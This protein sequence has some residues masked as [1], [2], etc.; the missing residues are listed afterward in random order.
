MSKA[1]ERERARNPPH[2]WVEQI[3]FK[4]VNIPRLI[5]D[6]I[7]CFFLLFSFELKEFITNSEKHPTQG[8]NRSVNITLTV[9]PSFPPFTAG[10]SCMNRLTSVPELS[11]LPPLSAKPHWVRQRMQQWSKEVRNHR[12]E[13]V[14]LAGRT[15]SQL[16]L[17]VEGSK[18]AAS[19]CSAHPLGHSMA[20]RKHG[21]FFL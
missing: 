21:N 6:M 11:F 4:K 17:L 8:Q 2:N 13:P 12:P 3:F 1:R 15:L 5:F 7:R 20:R 14:Q 9:L 18:P 16:T 10:Q 19:T